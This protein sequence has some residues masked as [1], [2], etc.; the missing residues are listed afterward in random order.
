MF[1]KFLNCTIDEC[2]VVMM[3]KSCQIKVLFVCFGNTCRSP[4]ALAVFNN[5][6]KQQ[7]LENKFEIDSAGT[8]DIIALTERSFSLFKNKYF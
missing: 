2:G 7:D 4:M 3:E 1:V 8:S 5:L 6:L